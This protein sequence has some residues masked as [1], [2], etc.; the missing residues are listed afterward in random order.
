MIEGLIAVLI[1]G[2]LTLIFG[3]I[4]G[5]LQIIIPQAILLAVIIY[6]LIRVRVKIARAE[7]E[8][9]RSRID[10]LEG[11]IKTMAKAST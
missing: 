1:L 3:I 11:K 6:L 5:F 10:Q 9:L 4:G 2:F 7:K 8:K